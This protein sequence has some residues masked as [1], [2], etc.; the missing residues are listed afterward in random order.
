[1]GEDAQALCLGEVRWVPVLHA[2]FLEDSLLPYHRPVTQHSLTTEKP[3]P[4]AVGPVQAHQAH[5]RSST[6]S[7]T[8]C[9]QQHPAASSKQPVPCPGVHPKG[10][11]SSFVG[12]TA[13]LQLLSPLGSA[14]SPPPTARVAAGSCGLHGSSQLH[15]SG[16]RVSQPAPPAAMCSPPQGLPKLKGGHRPWQTPPFSHNFQARPK[17]LS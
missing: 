15:L 17:C 3:Q 2:V 11:H 16:P 7:G 12:F 9:T 14:H 13:L 5:S 4:P 10:E 8:S 6:S 1:M